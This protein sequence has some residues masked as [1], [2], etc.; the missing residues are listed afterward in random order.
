[1][2]GSIV[3]R[4]CLE[5]VPKLLEREGPQQVLRPPFNDIRDSVAVPLAVVCDAPARKFHK[6]HNMTVKIQPEHLL[7][8]VWQAKGAMGVRAETPEGS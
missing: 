3:S 6:T 5:N 4:P 7:K 1:M 2:V 8:R